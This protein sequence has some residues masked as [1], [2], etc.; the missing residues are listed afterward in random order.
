MGLPKNIVIVED[1]VITQRYLQDILS[2]HQVHVS[3]CF[4]NALDTLEA[5]KRIECDMILMDINIKAQW[6]A[7]SYLK[8]F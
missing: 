8:K 4:D 3:G 7:Y 6:T 1:E 2:Q 5:L